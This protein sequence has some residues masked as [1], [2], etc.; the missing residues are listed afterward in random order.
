MDLVQTPSY[1]KERVLDEIRSLSTDQAA[2]QPADSDKG[3][4]SKVINFENKR[5]N[6]QRVLIPIMSAAAVILIAVI[7]LPMLNNPGGASI[8]PDSGVILQTE[9]YFTLQP[10][11]TAPDTSPR[12]SDLAAVEQPP[13][14]RGLIPLGRIG[15]GVHTEC[16]FSIK[17]KGVVRVEIESS[18]LQLYCYPEGQL[19]GVSPAFKTALAGG[20]CDLD[21]SGF[22][23]Y[24]AGKDLIDA[25]SFAEDASGTPGGFAAAL[26]GQQLRITVYFADDTSATQIY[27]LWVKKV[28]DLPHS[29]LLE[30]AGEGEPFVY[31]L[32]AELS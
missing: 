6:T 30:E 5:S 2:E 32:F 10:F 14:F 3:E 28:R 7:A 19:L 22:G 29:N 12:P 26:D 21:T 4:S 25:P 17:G 13:A 20:A 24:L 31:V 16:L 8:S 27:T 23:F 15:G 18:N 11:V 1:L 9:N